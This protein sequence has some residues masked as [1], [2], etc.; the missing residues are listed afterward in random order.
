MVTGA[1]HTARPLRLFV[2]SGEVSGDIGGAH[3]IRQMRRDY[4][5]VSFFG[6]GGPR[7]QQAGAEV[8]ALTNHLGTVG[9]TEV[10]RHFVP[11]ARLGWR[12]RESIRRDRPDVAILI[13][14]DVFNAGL[15][16]WLRR[17]GIP[18]VAY[19]PPQ[20]W[21]WRTVLRAMA[22]GFD[23][24][25]TPFPEEQREYA[26]ALPGRESVLVRHYLADALAPVTD[27][28]RASARAAL[29]LEERGRVVALLAGSRLHEVRRLTPVLMGAAQQLLARDAG[30][31]FVIPL[32]EEPL[33]PI[34]ERAVARHG[35]QGAVAI[36]RDSH[37]ALRA[38]DLGIV[39]SG[40]A[41]LEGALLG[42]PMVVVYRLSAATYAFIHACYRLRLMVRCPVSLPSLLVG[43]EVVPELLQGRATPTAVAREAWSVLSDPERQ[44]RMRA[45][46][47]A[48]RACV[49]AADT[50]QPV[51]SAVYRV[52]AASR[53]LGTVSLPGIHPEPDVSPHAG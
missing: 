17:Q 22:A 15:A 1:S 19:F 5:D 35:L 9:V 41:T 48:A 21:V 32:A 2:S 16:R 47:A 53:S 42:V 13:A 33:R 36:V 29:G 46:L 43:R 25:M 23:L 20:V 51:G 18:T 24:V 37:A 3:L 12:T 44:A 7:M 28:S 45:D 6:I 8:E 27:A 34:L 50:H 52:A 30:I 38:A 40:T 4:P 39:T 14:N 11:L 10:A 49:S 31:R 26:R